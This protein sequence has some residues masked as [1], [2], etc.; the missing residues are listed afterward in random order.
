MAKNVLT[1]LGGPSCKTILWK[2]EAG[3]SELRVN[4]AS[5]EEDNM[6]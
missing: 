5:M 6:G 1:V 2:V 4:L 3:L